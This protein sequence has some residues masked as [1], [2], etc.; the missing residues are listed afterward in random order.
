MPPCCFNLALRLLC[1]IQQASHPIPV[2]YLYAWHK[3]ILFFHFIHFM[4]E[5]CRCTNMPTTKA[6]PTC[7]PTLLPSLLL[8]ITSGAELALQQNIKDDYRYQSGDVP[9]P[10]AGPEIKNWLNVVPGNLVL[11]P[12]KAMIAAGACGIVCAGIGLLRLLNIADA[13]AGREGRSWSRKQEERE[14]SNL[15]PLQTVVGVQSNDCAGEAPLPL[16]SHPGSTVSFVNAGS[17]GLP[18]LRLCQGEYE[19]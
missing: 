13:N 4:R 17:A 3:N 11:G 1:R 7:F 12:T 8:L 6:M 5:R 15:H 19:F 10:K 9:W 2:I 14:A 16:D 18:H